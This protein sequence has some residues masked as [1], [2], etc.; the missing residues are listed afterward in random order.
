MT[1]ETTFQIVLSFTPK[2]YGA[3]PEAFKEYKASLDKW[4]ETLSDEA[5][6]ALKI[7]RRR[8]K[9]TGFTL[10]AFSYFL[11]IYLFL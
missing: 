2:S 3:S 6:T 7:R 5:K 9:G 11:L 4:Y 10:Y 8:R 1:L